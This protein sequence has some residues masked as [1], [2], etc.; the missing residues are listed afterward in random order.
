M[1]ASMNIRY[2]HKMS[3]E[4][5][6]PGQHNKILGNMVGTL[7]QTQKQKKK[8]PSLSIQ[9]S[10]WAD[11]I[12]NGFPLKSNWKIQRKCA[13]Q[14]LKLAKSKKDSFHIARPLLISIPTTSSF[15]RCHTSCFCLLLPRILNFSCFKTNV[16]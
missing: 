9:R 14:L 8:I 15:Q 12:Y 16:H 1:K 11:K 3:R 6:Y 4:F 7:Y 13:V 2:F 10:S 5:L